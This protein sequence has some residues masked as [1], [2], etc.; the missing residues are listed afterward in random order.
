M[1]KPATIIDPKVKPDPALEK[2][3]RRVFS[4]D[5]KLS[6]IQQADACQHG[7]LGKLLRRE[8]LYA[9]QL[10][11]WRRE[12]AEHGVAGLEK[13]SPGPTPKKSADQKRLEQ[14]E[15]ENA[16]LRREIEVKDGCLTLQKKALA[17]LDSLEQN[18]S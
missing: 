15:K 6:I 7:E 3:T 9:N 2:R 11:Q 17:L 1:P 18:E 5:Y 4:T 12:F 16:R 8:K 14:L 13:S 10:A